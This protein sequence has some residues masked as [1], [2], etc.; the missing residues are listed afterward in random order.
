MK[1]NPIVLIECDSE[2][3]KKLRDAYAALE[4]RVSELN[5]ERARLDTRAKEINEGPLTPQTVSKLEGVRT[6]RI[7]TWQAE[8]EIR[9][10]YSEWLEL[11][12]KALAKVR[13]G[14][15]AKISEVAADITEK[16]VAIG[17]VKCEPSIQRPGKITQGMILN[18]PSHIAAKTRDQ[19]LQ[20]ALLPNALQASIRN[21]EETARTVKDMEAYRDRVAGGG[22]SLA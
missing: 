7:V 13:E 17:Y 5:G 6:G 12:A 18:H 2:V 14:A 4:K 21:R 22:G 16:L 15:F 9:A 20:H 3:P 19:D 1:W 8:L 10:A 11:Y